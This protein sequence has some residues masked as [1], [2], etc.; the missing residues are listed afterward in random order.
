MSAIAKAAAAVVIGA[1]GLAP[2]AVA[3]SASA[4]P[5]PGATPAKYYANCD[6]A[7]ADGAAPIQKGQDGYS[8]KLDRDGDGIA[9]EN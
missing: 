9:C 8:D 1:A 7:R 6:A 5:F 4:A 2:F 3:A